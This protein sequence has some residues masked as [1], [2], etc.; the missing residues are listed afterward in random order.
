[1]GLDVRE[2]TVY[3][4][5]PTLAAL[6]PVAPEI[7]GT[8]A[9]ILLLATAAQESQ[10]THL[11]QLGGGPALGL[12]QM[13]SSTENDL[14]KWLSNDTDKLQL[15]RRVSGLCCVWEPGPGVLPLIASLPYAVAMARIAYYRHSAPL[16]A[17][18]DVASLWPLYKQFYNSPTG[19]ATQ[20][21]FYGNFQKL[22][23]PYLP[24]T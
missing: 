6:E 14:W 19:A 20:A 2:L 10:F 24:I 21:E 5:R 13:E 15:L 3:V 16:P 4:I 23:E 9:E 17:N 22:V 18:A 12:F 7:S 11:H 1:M 8:V